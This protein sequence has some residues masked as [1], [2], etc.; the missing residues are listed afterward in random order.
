[1]KKRRLLNRRNFFGACAAG[2]GG[3]GY[4]HLEPDWLEL[5][6][7]E[8]RIGKSGDTL[9]IL[10]LS[11]FHASRVV[12]L[13]HIEASVQIG[14]DAKFDV[15]CLTGDFIT[16]TYE[17]F[18]QFGQLLARLT[19]SAPGFACLGN[20][21]GG[22]WSRPR[23]GYPT[24]AKV[25][26]MLEANNFKILRNQSQVIEIAGKPWQFVGLGDIWAKDFQPHTAFATAKKDLRTILLSHNPDTKEWLGDFKWDVMLS[27]HTHGGQMWIPLLGA[28]FAPVVDHRYVAGMN[29]WRDRWIH[30]TKGVGNLHGMRLNCRPEVSIAQILA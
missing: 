5:N 27:G 6:I 25:I 17:S 15:V 20:H 28:P 7:R 22:E 1:M 10:H 8:A 19:E 21:D 2:L 12:S 18:D 3:L 13:D 24:A 9:R 26:A 30:T 23:G 16:S 14:L 29:P 11:D 4:M